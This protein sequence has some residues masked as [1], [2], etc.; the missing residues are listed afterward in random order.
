MRTAARIDRNQPEIVK[1]LRGIGCS[2][3]ITSQLKNCF[4]ILVGYRGKTYLMEI[5][6]P[7]QPLSNRQLTEGEEKFKESW[8]G[9]PYYVVHEV[10]EAIRIVTGKI[11]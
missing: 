7:L 9:S 5:K 8:R 10:D 1:A 11:I 4:D 6:D 2:V 3:L